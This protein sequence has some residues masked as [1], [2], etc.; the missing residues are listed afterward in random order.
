MM[1]ERASS[2]LDCGYGKS[3]MWRVI[4]SLEMALFRSG[5]NRRTSLKVMKGPT[6]RR[7]SVIV[8]ETRINFIALNIGIAAI[9][10]ECVM[11]CLVC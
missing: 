3:G 9:S 7:R 4:S 6:M 11:G 2:E 10:S 8:V 1:R 5:V